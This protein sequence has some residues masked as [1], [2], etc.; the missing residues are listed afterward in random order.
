MSRPEEPEPAADP[1][2]PRLETPRAVLRTLGPPDVDALYAIFADPRVTRYWS[3]PP[4]A[5]RAAAEALLANIDEG[6]RSGRLF[7]WGIARRA[8]DHVIGTVTLAAIDHGNR[9]AQLGYALGADHWGGGWMAEALTAAIDHAFDGLELHRLEADVDP[10]NEASIRSLERL[11]FER[12]GYLRERWHIHGEV[13]D[14]ML[15]GRLAPE[16][17]AAR[18]GVGPHSG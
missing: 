16:W 18:T 8:D 1:P 3:S 7:Q 15:F 10:R 14:S 11:G 13:A 2:L 6:R 12:D 9:R 5:D 17:R 4:L